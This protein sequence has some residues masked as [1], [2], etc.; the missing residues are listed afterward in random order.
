MNDDVLKA[1]YSIFVAKRDALMVDINR[2]ISNSAYVEKAAEVLVGKIS[3]LVVVDKA[4]AQTEAFLAQVVA[5]EI[6]ASNLNKKQTSSKQKDTNVN[7]SLENIE[8]FLFN[9][10]NPEGP[11]PSTK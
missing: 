1:T 2:L 10:L 4:I 3:E 11:E 5:Q 7:K 6:Y 8:N 9:N